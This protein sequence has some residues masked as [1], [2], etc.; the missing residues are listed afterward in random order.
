V[1][2]FDASAPTKTTADKIAAAANYDDNNNII[3]YYD[4]INIIIIL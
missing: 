3:E 1:E 2:S 4:N